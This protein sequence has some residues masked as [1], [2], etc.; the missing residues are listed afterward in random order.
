[1]DPEARVIVTAHDTTAA[2]FRSA[3]KNLRAFTRGISSARSVAAAFGVV[4]SGRAFANWITNGLRAA[5]VTGEHAE[6]I[7]RAKDALEGMK[8]ASDELAASIGS[9]LAPAMEVTAQALEGWRQILAPT[10]LEKLQEQLRGTYDEIARINDEI[11]ATDNRG[12][13]GKVFFGT[14]GS[15]ALKQDLAVAKQT[16][17]EL[18]SQIVELKRA[19]AQL[20]VF[21]P[22][23]RR[24]GDFADRNAGAKR[25][26]VAIDYLDEFEEITVQARKISEDELLKPFPTD[27]VNRLFEPLKEESQHVAEFMGETFKDSFADWMIGTER[28]FGDLLKRMAAQ[29]A[30]SAVFQS[31]AGLFG[32]PTTWLG[33]FFGGARAE[34]G[35]VSSG[36]GYLVGENGPEMF[37]PGQSGMISP[38]GGVV[39]NS[40]PTFNF[41]GGSS[42]EQAAAFQAMLNERDKRLMGQIQESRK[43]GRF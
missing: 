11:E 4:L 2:A 12:I 35:P 40:S 26:Q 1:M 23:M 19:Q 8:K 42:R 29:L 27:E 34:G 9:K 28:D 3:D 18:L 6:Q 36:K 5:E 22:N 31:V 38:G 13:I 20:E 30:A 14:A 15:G 17:Q 7:K 21:A 37:F 10:E 24:I 43:R 32:G 25:P 33:R 39:I 16:A 41:S